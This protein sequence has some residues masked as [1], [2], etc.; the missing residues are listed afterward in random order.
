MAAAA[1][2]ITAGATIAGLLAQQQAQQRQ[3]EAINR[4]AALRQP[5]IDFFQGI[6]SDPNAGISNFEELR[7]GLQSR[8]ESRIEEAIQRAQERARENAAASGRFTSGLIGERLREIE[9]AG[10]EQLTNATTDINEFATNLINQRQQQAASAL[11]N[12]SLTDP[13]AAGLLNASQAFG[14]FSDLL[15]SNIVGPI[16]EEVG[17]IN[18]SRIEDVLTN[19][20]NPQPSATATFTPPQT[21]IF[22]APSFGAQR[23]IGSSSIFRAPRLGAQRGFRNFG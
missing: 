20:F 16:F 15:L 5:A 14:N 2:I 3:Q 4:Q 1:P 13:R 12:P 17:Q 11:A 18:R 9:E 22:N 19:L 8:A 7:S 21:S 23:P 6:L 10:L